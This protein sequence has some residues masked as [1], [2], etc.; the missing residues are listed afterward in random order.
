MDITLFDEHVHSCPL[1][2]GEAVMSFLDVRVDAWAGG[3]SGT[4]SRSGSAVVAGAEV[5]PQ[6]LADLLRKQGCILDPTVL[7]ADLSFPRRNIPA[8]R[9]N[10]A[11]FGSEEQTGIRQFTLR[12]HYTPFVF[13]DFEAQPPFYW[14]RDGKVKARVALQVQ[15]EFGSLRMTCFDAAILTGIGND[16]LERAWQACVEAERRRAFVNLF[17][18]H[19]FRTMD[20][21]GVAKAAGG[22]PESEPMLVVQAV[23]WVAAMGSRP[24]LPGGALFLPGVWSRA[25][26]AFLRFEAPPG[27]F[28]AGFEEG[29]SEEEIWEDFDPATRP[30]TASDSSPFGSQD[31]PED[32]ETSDSPPAKVR[33]VA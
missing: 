6:L 31:A 16:E 30:S 20:V 19:A 26:R 3:R 32:E 14:A 12:C 29:G 22:T 9:T 5:P 2:S 4:L 8:L 24:R 1:V 17:N 13:S 11:V 33:R 27:S 7:K 10:R 21:R 23:E 25:A 18:Q 28:A 15:D